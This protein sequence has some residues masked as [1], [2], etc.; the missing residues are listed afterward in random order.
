MAQL[1]DQIDN[2]NRARKHNPR[3]TSK[4]IAQELEKQGFLDLTADQIEVRIQ[5]R[6]AQK[7]LEAQGDTDG[8]K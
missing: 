1:Q 7:Q 2:V 5:D 3:L 6:I 4:E 8:T